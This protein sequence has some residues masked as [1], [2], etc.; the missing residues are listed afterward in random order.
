MNR[1][2]LFVFSLT[3]LVS[4]LTGCFQFQ[5]N[6]LTRRDN[7]DEAFQMG[8]YVPKIDNFFIILDASTS[9]SMP[10]NNEG[11]VPKFKVAIDFLKRMNNTM[12]EMDINGSLMTFGRGI[13]QLKRQTEIVY[14]PTTYSRSGLEQSLN[15]LSFSAEG[16]SPAGRAIKAVSA[17]LGSVQGDSAVIFISDGMNLEGDPRGKARALENRYGKGTCFIRFG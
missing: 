14:G 16:N 13:N 15:S 7:L 1:K 17:A 4:L 10:Y 12:P 5:P 11:E 3:V 2:R 9:M 8:E 6:F